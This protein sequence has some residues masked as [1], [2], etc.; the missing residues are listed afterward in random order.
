M[1]A[2]HPGLTPMQ[3]DAALIAGDLTNDAGEP[4]R[5]DLFGHGIIN[6][7]KAVLAALALANGGS[8]DP[9]PILSGSTSALNFGSFQSEFEISLQNV[10][11]PTL[12]ITGITTGEPWLSVTP[13]NIDSTGAGTYGINVNRAGLADGSYSSEVSFTSAT[14]NFNLNV[15]MQVASVDLSANAGTHF[16]ILLDSNGNTVSQTFVQEPTVGFYNYTLTDV[17]PGDYQLFAGS[18]L[19]N[20]DFLC[21]GGE[22]CGAFRTLDAPETFTVDADRNDLN[23]ISGFRQTISA[24]TATA[25]GAP[26]PG[27]VPEAGFAIDKSKFENSQ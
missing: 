6:A 23:F 8:S 25:Q 4:G 20:D 9:G 5:D 22:A 2:V 18:D 11:T 14:N 3:L 1:K 13:R 10:G 24:G 17:Q 26:V 27:T 21:D 19:D 12:D 16:V 7:Q 15:V